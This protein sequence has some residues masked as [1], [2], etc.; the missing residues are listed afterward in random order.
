[1]KAKVYLAGPV[2]H[3]DDGGESWRQY[4]EDNYDMFEWQNPLGKYNISFEEVSVAY[5]ERH[6]QELLKTVDKNNIVTPEE[7]VRQDKEEILSCDAVLVGWTGVWSD[8]TLREIEFA[9][10][11]LNRPVV[12]WWLP[13]DQ[14]SIN[15]F[16]KHIQDD[17][18]YEFFE[19]IPLWRY[20]G[21]DYLDPS[22]NR[23]IEYLE[24]TLYLYNV[25]ND[26]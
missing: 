17:K 20:E 4:L 18:V 16:E 9:S 8:G 13:F 23:C 5:N 6:Y 3:A 24:D 21:V 1:M 19:Q 14:E 7:V 11:Q 26:C 25:D 15:Q 10:H 22:L 2:H 12:M